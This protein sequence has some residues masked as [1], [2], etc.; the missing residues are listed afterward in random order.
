MGPA[1]GL[2]GATYSGCKRQFV[3]L[4]MI[5]GMGLLGTYYPS[6]KVNTLD[7]SSNYA[8]TVM[9]LVNG[10]GSLSGI[11]SPSLTSFMIPDVSAY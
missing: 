5:L 3:N 2:I 7:L 6:L 4:Y 1:I 11:I 9:G 10:F 8:G